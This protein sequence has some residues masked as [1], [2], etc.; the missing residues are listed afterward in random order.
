MGYTAIYDEETDLI[1]FMDGEKVLREDHA[2]EF[3]QFSR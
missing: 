2:M 3:D 1:R